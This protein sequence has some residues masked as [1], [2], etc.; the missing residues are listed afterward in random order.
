MVHRCAMGLLLV[1][2]TGCQDSE[3]AASPGDPPPR[4]VVAGHDADLGGDSYDLN[5]AAITGHALT[6]SVSFAGGCREHAFTLVIGA[7]FAESSP[8][9]LSAVLKHEANGDRCEAWLTET[10]VFDLD[11]IQSRYREAY[12]PGAGTVVLQ[13]RGAP[14]VPDA[15]VDLV[16]EFN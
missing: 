13:L 15:I 1:A 9:Q 10:H 16:Y 5:S 4:V 6:V 8:V 11:L 3:R 2:A 14:D 7:S 12:G